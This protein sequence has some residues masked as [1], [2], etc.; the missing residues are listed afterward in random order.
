MLN[1]GSFQGPRPG[2]PNASGCDLTAPDVQSTARRRPCS[3]CWNAS[4]P[5]SR[6]PAPEGPFTAPR[7]SPAPGPQADASP[8]VS[9][10]SFLR[11]RGDSPYR[12]TSRFSLLDSDLPWKMHFSPPAS[13]GCV[14]ASHLHLALRL[15]CCRRNEQRFLISSSVWTETLHRR[16]AVVGRT[17]PHS[18]WQQNADSFRGCGARGSRD[19]PVGS[20]SRRQS[21]LRTGGYAVLERRTRPPRTVSVPSGGPRR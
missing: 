7:V 18:Q 9:D 1:R 13:V 19:I 20:E 12:G 21:F 4:P 3:P 8:S 17:A 2:P 6:P 14:R 10:T 11:L 16:A 15:V 5:H